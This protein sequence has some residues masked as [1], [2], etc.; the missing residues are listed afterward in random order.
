MSQNVG[1]QLPAYAAPTTEKSKRPQAM[2][3]LCPQQTSMKQI[4]GGGGNMAKLLHRNAITYVH[5]IHEYVKVTWK[6]RR[7]IVNVKF[8]KLLFPEDIFV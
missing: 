2:G 7:G 6:I 8:S 4:G 5:E 3:D 1:K